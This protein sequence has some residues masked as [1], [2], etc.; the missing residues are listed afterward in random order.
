MSSV[1]N[2]QFDFGVAGNVFESGCRKTCIQRYEHH[3]RGGRAKH[4]G[5]ILAQVVRE[6]TN[7]RARFKSAIN[8][9]L[10]EDTK[11]TGDFSNRGFSNR[12]FGTVDQGNGIRI[13]IPAKKFR[14]IHWSDYPK[15]SGSQVIKISATV[16]VLGSLTIV[17]TVSAR[18]VGWIMIC[19]STPKLEVISVST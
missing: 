15:T 8:E 2:E 9:R 10:R 12:I 1:R 16:A 4:D 17:A 19:G 14:D 7:S 6:E 5:V 18:S 13:R 11:L 3:S